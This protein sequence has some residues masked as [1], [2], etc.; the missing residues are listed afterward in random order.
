MLRRRGLP[1]YVHFRA[2]SYRCQRSNLSDRGHLA[3]GRTAPTVRP[4]G[5]SAREHVKHHLQRR[6]V[7]HEPELIS[8]AVLKDVGREMEHYA[9]D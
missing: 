6:R 8:R 1:T 3:Q 9:V 2:V 5:Q 4:R 7:D